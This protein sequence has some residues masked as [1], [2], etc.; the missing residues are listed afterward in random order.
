MGIQEKLGFTSHRQ[1]REAKIKKDIKRIREVNE[2]DPFEAFISNQHIRYVYYKETEKSWVTL[3]ECVFYK[4]LKP[5]PLICW[6]EQLKQSKVV[7]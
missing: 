5:S 6:L 1:K 2:Q 3:T 4:I 7:D